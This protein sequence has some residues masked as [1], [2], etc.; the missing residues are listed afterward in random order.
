MDRTVGT[1]GVN[2]SRGF[3]YTNGR[4]GAWCDGGPG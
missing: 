4:P 2:V 1:L 3:P